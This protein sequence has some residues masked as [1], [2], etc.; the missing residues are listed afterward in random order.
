MT[1][2]FLGGLQVCSRRSQVRRQRVT[3]AVPSDCLPSDLRPDESGTNDLLQNHVRGYRRFPSFRTEGKRKSSSPLYSDSFLHSSRHATTEVC[4]GTG[5]RLAS[6]LVS[7]KRPRTHERRTL[8]CM[9]S[10]STSRHVRAT[11]SDHCNPV[12]LARITIAFTRSGSSG[13][14]AANSAGVSTSGSLTGVST[15]LEPW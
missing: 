6:V 2:E 1:Q 12:L 14:K 8:T 15:K 11:S 7:P 10:G 5:L 9:R 4:N 3:E 13:T